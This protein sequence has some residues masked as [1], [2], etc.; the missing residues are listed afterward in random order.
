MKKLHYLILL[1]PF[2]LASCTSTPLEVVEETYSDSIA[3]TVRIYKDESKEILL[4]EVQ[5]YEDGQKKLEGAFKDGQRTGQW[6]Y[7]YADGKLW[8]QGVYKKGI[9]NGLKTIWHPNGQ[10]Y[11]EG[12]LKMGERVGIWKFWDKEGN[13]IK[14]IDYDHPKK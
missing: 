11:Y 13:L 3:K 14:E 4:K 10:K 6:Q 1:I 5:Y 7:W 2:W 8:S 12:K 9:E